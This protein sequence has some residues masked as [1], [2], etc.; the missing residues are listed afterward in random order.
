MMLGN[1]P[2]KNRIEVLDRL[3]DTYL[4]KEVILTKPLGIFN[5]IPAGTSGVVKKIKPSGILMVEWDNGEKCGIPYE[6]NCVI[7]V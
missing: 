1:M 4:N 5:Q 3:A 2:Y 6:T 7:P